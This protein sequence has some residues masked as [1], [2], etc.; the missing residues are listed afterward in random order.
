LRISKGRGESAVKKI[1][2]NLRQMEN[3]PQAT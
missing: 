1:I 3:P 2:D